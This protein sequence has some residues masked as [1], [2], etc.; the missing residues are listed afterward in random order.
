MTTLTHPI[1]DLTGFITEGQIVLDRNLDKQGIY[2][3]INVLPCLSRLMN[4]G[5]WGRQNPRGSSQHFQ[6]SVFGL[7]VCETSR[8]PGIDYRRESELSD[9]DKKYLELGR[10]YEQKICEPRVFQKTVRLRRLWIWRAEPCF[11]P[12]SKRTHASDGRTN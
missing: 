7:Y 8:N 3:P 5:H 10:Q 2:P 6:S 4:D 12:A 1:P 9:L 11:V